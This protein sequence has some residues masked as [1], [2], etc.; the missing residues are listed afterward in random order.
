MTK[1]FCFK[2]LILVF[3]AFNLS[4]FIGVLYHTEVKSQN[5]PPL[6]SSK[7]SD[8]SA[9]NKAAINTL[10][11]DYTSKV[12]NPAEQDQAKQLRNRLIGI[13]RDQIDAVFQDFRRGKRTRTQWLQFILDFIEIGASTAIS[14]T[15]GERAKTVIGEGLSAFQGSRASLNKRFQLEEQQILSNKMIANRAIVMT[16]ILGRLNNN[17]VDYSWEMAR[18][19]LREYFNAGTIENALDSLSASTGE[20]AQREQTRLSQLKEKAGIVGAVSQESRKR[21]DENFDKITAIMKEYEAAKDPNNPNT[22]TD[23]QKE[24]L[25]KYKKIFG[26]VLANEKLVAELNKLPNNQNFS[27]GFRN[28]LKGLLT[29]LEQ[30]EDLTAAQY[31]NL[32]LKLSIAVSNNQ[33]LSE[34]FAESLVTN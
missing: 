28:I 25:K 6:L 3:T 1:V 11:S 9:F 31:E 20:E 19:D 10:I 13:G 5:L 24:V 26:K 29:K 34:M 23:S 2:H 22:I 30:N 16:R 12:K 8:P 15:N 21:A 33:T 14:L 27:E 17:V 4:F 32:L 18:S 7:D